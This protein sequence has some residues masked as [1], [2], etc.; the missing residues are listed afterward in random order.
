M[1]AAAAAAGPP[2]PD[3]DEESDPEELGPVHG[4]RLPPLNPFAAASPVAASPSH[5]TFDG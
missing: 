3:D 4:P 1:A 2:I 5:V